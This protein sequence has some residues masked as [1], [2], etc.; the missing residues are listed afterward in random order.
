MSLKIA[1]SGSTGLVGGEI[2]RQF[3]THGY[4][5]IPL[6]RKTTK[7]NIEEPH[8]QWDIASKTIDVNNLEGC[9]AVIHLAGASIAGKRWSKNYK[10]QILMSRV[11]GTKLLSQALTRL[12]HPPKILLSAS[13][14]GYYGYGDVK[15]VF[16]EKSQKGTGFLSDV[17]QEWELATREAENAGIRVVHMRFGLVLGN[18][19]GALKKMLP[20]FKIGLGGKLGNG[21]QIYC[22]IANQEIPRII[23]FIIENEHIKGPINFVASQSVSNAEFTKILGACLKRPVILPAPAFAIKLALG[24][25]GEGL[26]LS[27]AHI[28]PMR[29]KEFD[30]QFQFDDLS[31]ALNSILYQKT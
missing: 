11:E 13:A 27:G 8:I 30:Y 14:V 6:T 21:Q 28:A 19:G 16:D 25:M 26:L 29:L 31:S 18:E 10:E 22:W 9:D 4:D 20:I 5:I 3:K 23:N 2:V 1:I 24:E 17:C 15:N 7:H 12:N